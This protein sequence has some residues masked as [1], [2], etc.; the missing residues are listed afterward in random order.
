M[1][2]TEAITVKRV[3]L[4]LLYPVSCAEMSSKR[5]RVAFCWLNLFRC[6][7]RGGVS[8]MGPRWLHHW[9]CML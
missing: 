7:F 6:H 2:L 8:L 9:P 1:V 3:V 5:M 4:H